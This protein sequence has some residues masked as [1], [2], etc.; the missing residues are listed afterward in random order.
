[1]NKDLS[2]Y[3]FNLILVSLLL[4]TFCLTCLIG[5][6][7]S[8]F[9][10]TFF[11]VQSRENNGVQKLSSAVVSVIF[12]FRQL[13]FL[14]RFGLCPYFSVIYAPQCSSPFLYGWE[15]TSLRRPILT[16]FFCV[17]E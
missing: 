6:V 11:G 1:M 10:K 4:N 3:S 15:E 13:L 14:Q 9:M 17:V 5:L 8:S 7:L 2:I 16:A 12:F